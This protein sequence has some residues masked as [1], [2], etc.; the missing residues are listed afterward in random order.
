MLNCRFR[1][2]K[3]VSWLLINFWRGKNIS[4]V[5]PN[6]PTHSHQSGENKVEEYTTKILRDFWSQDRRRDWLLEGLHQLSIKRSIDKVR[7]LETKTCNIVVYS[8]IWSVN[9]VLLAD[10]IIER[11]GRKFFKFTRRETKYTRQS[12]SFKI[13]IFEKVSSRKLLLSF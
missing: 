7:R 3:V 2:C 10:N 5:D 1:I 11:T 12:F 9:H 8:I 13:L 4:Q 6:L